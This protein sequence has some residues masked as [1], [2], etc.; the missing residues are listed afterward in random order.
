MTAQENHLDG[1]CFTLICGWHTHEDACVTWEQ[2]KIVIKHVDDEKAA[3]D[4][5]CLYLIR[6]RG[7]MAKAL[8]VIEGSPKLCVP[9]G[10][11]F[12]AE[13]YDENVTFGGE[14]ISCFP[15]N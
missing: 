11:V 12:D 4:N 7:G 5:A 15:A 9:R 13:E 10:R 14:I 6:D 2:I 3:A 1:K 8:L